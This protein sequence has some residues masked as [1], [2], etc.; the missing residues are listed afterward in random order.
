MVKV[1]TILRL[2]A[3]RRYGVKAGPVPLVGGRDSGQDLR[4]KI[5]LLFDPFGARW[6]DI[7]EGAIAA[8]G[9]GFDGVWIYDHLAGS[10]HRQDR[11]V[12]AWTTL[13]AIAAT[14]PRIAI[15]PMVLNVAN[16]DAGTLGVMAATLQEVSEGRLLLG[17]GAGGGRT[18]PYAAEQHAFGRP[19]PGDVARRAA[20]EAAV[21]TLREVWSGNVGG[22]GGFLR[23]DPPPPIILGGF[24][25]KMAALAGR[26]ADGVNLPG[27]AGFARLLQVAR[28]AK[29]K[30]GRPSSPF[31]VTVSSEL[32]PRAL[33]KLEEQHVDRAVVFVSAPFADNVRRLAADRG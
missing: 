5:D 2:K 6:R 7:R 11:V 30:A 23:P 26:V 20:V 9:E 1:G 17:L 14:V 29:A 19:V 10:V 18:T 24:G 16:R 25:P 12:E 28:E 3:V 13:T 8:E 32:R 27:G 4:M 31:V 22:V 15:G 21:T 33:A